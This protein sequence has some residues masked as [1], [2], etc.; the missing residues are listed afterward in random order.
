MCNKTG[1]ESNSRS[2]VV[3]FYLQFV[4]LWLWRHWH[5]SRRL[6]RYCRPRP[7]YSGRDCSGIAKLCLLKY[8][9]LCWNIKGN[10]CI[11]LC[12]SFY[13]LTIL[14][15]SVIYVNQNNFVHYLT[16]LWRYAIV[17]LNQSVEWAR[18]SIVIQ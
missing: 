13:I 5:C 12:R 10:V 18:Y 16:I 14:L 11:I 1:A 6:G 4:V 17:E 15:N 7:I 3:L 2:S 9:A 8:C